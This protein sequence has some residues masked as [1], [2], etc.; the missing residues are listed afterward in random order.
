MSKYQEESS[1]ASIN[2]TVNTID[3]NREDS[4]HY[5]V[6][7]SIVI[8]F[9]ALVIILASAIIIYLYLKRRQGNK[10]TMSQFSET[11]GDEPVASMCGDGSY[12]SPGFEQRNDNSLATNSIAKNE[13]QAPVTQQSA[14]GYPPP[15]E[16]GARASKVHSY[17][18]ELESHEAMRLYSIPSAS[19]VVLPEPRGTRG[20]SSGAV[21]SNVPSQGYRPNTTSNLNPWVLQSQRRPVHSEIESLSPQSHIAR[22]PQTEDASLNPGTTSLLSRDSMQPAK[23]PRN[24]LS[25]RSKTNHPRISSQPSPPWAPLDLDSRLLEEEPDPTLRLPNRSQGSISAASEFQSVYACSSHSQLGV[26]ELDSSSLHQAHPPPRFPTAVAGENYLIENQCH[27]VNSAY[28]SPNWSS[29]Y[30]GPPQIMQQYDTG[31]TEVHSLD[32]SSLSATLS[33]PYSEPYHHFSNL[34]LNT[35]TPMATTT[36][37]PGFYNPN[38]PTDE[39]FHRPQYVKGSSYITEKQN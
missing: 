22:A 25:R 12:Y 36:P 1:N 14:S 18:P 29:V 7:A 11:R 8:P 20:T 33:A 32:T 13:L 26:T 24:R 38:I 21:I 17:R 16:L 37:S 15:S 31:L 27:T 6:L 19:V 35:G 28:P 10:P 39:T 30:M 2:P 34:P 3:Q 5:L 9:S 4:L 23:K